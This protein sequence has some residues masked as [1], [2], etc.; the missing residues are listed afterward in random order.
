MGYITTCNAMNCNQMTVENQRDSLTT[1]KT[2]IKT[3]KTIQNKQ[4]KYNT[5]PGYDD[6][7]MKR[8]LNIRYRLSLNILIKDRCI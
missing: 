1:D 5:V 6:K 2:Y 7:Y 4:T 8:T 3:L